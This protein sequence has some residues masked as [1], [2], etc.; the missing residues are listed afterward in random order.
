MKT[1]L[2]LLMLF[3]FMASCRSPQVDKEIGHSYSIDSQGNL[4]YY[5]EFISWFDTDT[6][7][8]ITHR[9][10]TVNDTSPFYITDKKGVYYKNWSWE[11]EQLEWAHPHSFHL[12]DRFIAKD[13]DHVYYEGFIIEWVDVESF[14]SLWQNYY[15]DKDSIYINKISI[16]TQYADG[17]YQQIYSGTMAR[18]EWE[19]YDSF[20]VSTVDI[21]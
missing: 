19:D 7:K 21:L 4:Y 17:I 5:D 10:D 3:F 8:I 20:D 14:E 11:I 16:S 9:T 2:I 12:I 6:F 1:I 15:R 13:N 18:L